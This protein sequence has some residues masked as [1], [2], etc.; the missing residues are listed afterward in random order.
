MRVLRLSNAFGAAAV[1][2]MLVSQ[3]GGNSHDAAPPNLHQST[4]EAHE[5]GR[6]V[7]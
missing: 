2:T 7:T 1:L 3:V 6:T 5:G 4:S